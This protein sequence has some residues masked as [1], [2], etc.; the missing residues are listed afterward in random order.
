[1]KYLFLLT[2]LFTLTAQAKTLRVAIVDT[3]L[4]LSDERFSEHLCPEG[5][6]DFSASGIK[7]T[8]GHGTFIA[9]LIQKYAG[10]GNYCFLVYK[11]YSENAPGFVNVENEVSALREA[12]N[13]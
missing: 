12:V 2:L 1:M 5:H 8:V 4:D 7:D 9:G 6:K 11:Y 10:K 3:G 13:S